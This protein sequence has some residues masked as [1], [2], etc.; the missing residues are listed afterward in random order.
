MDSNRFTN[1]ELKKYTA[2][3]EKETEKR[4]FLTACFWILLLLFLIFQFSSAV[5]LAGTEALRLPVDF[6]CWWFFFI[7][8]RFSHIFFSWK[9]RHKIMHFCWYDCS[10]ERLTHN[11]WMVHT[12]NAERAPV[13]GHF[14]S[15]LNLTELW[16]HTMPPY[17]SRY[18]Y[19]QIFSHL[20]D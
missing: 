19:H 5:A 20:E 9:F 11:V 4:C 8:I 15:V 18:C 6:D 17:I 2:S 14:C 3:Y 1:D 10:R 13:Y 16:Y 7:F 12:E